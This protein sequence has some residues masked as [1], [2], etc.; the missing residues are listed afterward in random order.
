MSI[1]QRNVVKSTLDLRE[2]WEM[3]KDS[4]E[5]QSRVL[6][7][8]SWPFYWYD[9]SKQ[10]IVTLKDGQFV[11]YKL[12]ETKVVLPDTDEAAVKNGIGGRVLD[13]LKKSRIKLNYK[14]KVKDAAEAYKRVEAWEKGK[15]WFVSEDGSAIRTLDFSGWEKPVMADYV[16]KETEIT[17]D[18]ME[19]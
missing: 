12:S 11:P 16:V 9:E 18:A 17:Y 13:T 19:L 6:W 4:S 1:E 2:W 10:W 3:V 7:W 15:F 8:E 14:N 5:A